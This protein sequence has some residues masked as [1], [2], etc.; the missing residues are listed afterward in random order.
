MLWCNNNGNKTYWRSV[1]LII[2][3]Q[4]GLGLLLSLYIVILPI[5]RIERMYYKVYISLKW[6]D[7]TSLIAMNP[8]VVFVICT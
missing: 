4:V 2:N 3:L 1:L 8:L 5:L 7:I 6:I